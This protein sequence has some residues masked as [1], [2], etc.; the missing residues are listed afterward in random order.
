MQSNP[1]YNRTD[2]ISLK[3]GSVI[4]IFIIRFNE[5]VTDQVAIKQVVDILTGQTAVD[6]LH[7]VITSVTVVGKLNVLLVGAI[8]VKLDLF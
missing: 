8:V 7:V 3:A 6:T 2:V 5:E 1:L 4:V